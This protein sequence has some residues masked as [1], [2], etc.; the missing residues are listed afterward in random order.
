V[1]ILPSTRSFPC[2]LRIRR[3][4]MSGHKKIA[5]VGN[6][7]SPKCCILYVPEPT[8]RDSVP[9]CMPPFSYKRGGL[10]RYEEIEA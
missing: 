6:I 10:Q 3:S 2:T 7:C 4:R 1:L 8:C 9:L 5:L